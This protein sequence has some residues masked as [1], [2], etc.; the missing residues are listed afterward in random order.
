MRWISAQ[1]LQSWAGRR[2]CEDVLPE[3]LRRLVRA[4]VVAPGSAH[5]PSGE[6]IQVGGWD[7]VVQ[8]PAGNEFVPDGWSGWELSRRHDTTT[9][10]NDD[11]EK[12]TADPLQLDRATASFVFV[13]PRRWNAKDDWAAAK[14]A[15][16]EWANV[17]ALDADHLEQWLEQAPAVGAWLARKLGK[18]PNGV[19]SIDDYWTE[20][21]CG[22]NPP[23]TPES[24][25]AGRNDD[26]NRV[27]EWLRNGTG[28]LRLTAESPQEAFAFVAAALTLL[29]PEEQDQIRSRFLLADD[30]TVLR[31]IVT[32]G[33]QLTI[34]WLATDVTSIGAATQRGHR[35]IVPTTERE[36]PG[37]SITLTRPDHESLA[38]SLVTTGMSQDQTSTL[39]QEANDS[40]TILRRRLAIVPT[41]P[42]WG[43][44]ANARALI[45]AVLAISW[46]EQSPAEQTVVAG[47]AGTEYAAVAA[48]IARWARVSDAPVQQNGAVCSLRAPRDA[49]Y[50]LSP[51]IT[52][53]DLDQYRMAVTAVL[54]LR[55]PRLDLE[56]AERWLANIHGK[57]F[58]HSS[59]L[60]RGLAESL[61]FLSLTETVGGER[62]HDVARTIVHNL[63]TT[64]WERWYSLDHVLP[65]LAEAAPAIFLTQLEAALDHD[66]DGTAIFFESEGMMGGD[67]AT[68]LLW[69]LELLAWYPEHLTRVTLALARI[70]RTQE[71]AERILRAIFLSWLPQTSATSQQRGAALAVIMQREPGIGWRLLMNLWPKN[72]DVGAHHYEPKWREKPPV[73]PITVGERI[74]ADLIVVE[75]A[76]QHT[77]QDPARLADLIKHLGTAPP[78]AQTRL[79]EL[80]ATFTQEQRDETARRGVWNALREEVNKHRKFQDAPWALREEALAR[81]DPTIAALT[82]QDPVEQH[83]WLFKDA[84][85]TMPLHDPDPGML[86]TDEALAQRRRTAVQEIIAEHGVDGVCSLATRTEYPFLLGSSCAA[87][88][89]DET[90]M[91]AL[92]ASDDNHA[93]FCG[94]GYAYGRYQADGMN[95]VDQTLAAHEEWSKNAIAALLLA[96]PTDRT[97]WERVE[98]HE[99]TNEYWR[100]TTVFL[101]RDTP[102]ED[103]A[104]TLTHLLNAQQV[105]RALELASMLAAKTPTAVLTQV[106]DSILPALEAEPKRFSQLGYH[107]TQILNALDTRDDIEPGVIGRHEWIMLPL[108]RHDRTLR[109]HDELAKAPDL[110]AQMVNAIYR[111]DNEDD[112]EPATDEVIARAHHAEE[113]LSSWR[114][115]PGT[116]LD[117]TIDSGA[118]MDWVT[119]A[120]DACADRRDGCDRHIGQ[121]LAH[122]PAGTDGAW[123]C[124]AV[125]IVIDHVNTRALEHG[126]H[127]G[128]YNKRGTVT[129]DPFAGGVQERALVE[130]YRTWS[131]AL[132]PAWPRTAAILEELADQYDREAHREDVTAQLR[133]L[134]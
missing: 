98:Q 60:R 1:D 89:A 9:K 74:A 96:I 67:H 31:E 43:I 25:L 130:Q 53:Q 56:P 24:V 18:Y 62:G 120:R 78:H 119:R 3:L 84:Y 97:T 107:V 121:V 81:F 94:M 8:A 6:S 61:I 104:Y 68:G 64:D 42:E 5:F 71:R 29:P 20:Y 101:K 21:S 72:Y 34:G 117:G 86:L 44:P 131:R 40:I 80:L 110:F 126:F 19:L 39:L 79:Q 13:T 83:A 14:H 133:R 46:N 109:L 48:T 55:D 22:T 112:Q 91:L 69:A 57:E 82:P 108:L 49:W 129:A 4:T 51:F 33:Q 50:V 58:P 41:P 123:P 85:P 95:W 124:E 65:M 87:A 10:A 116:N 17:Y 75:L 23:L 70:A 32:T 90:A 37:Q 77:G 54:G 47:I 26:M 118:L 113:L 88:G 2:D 52:R 38:K 103:I 15:T 114:I 134:R 125:R 127:D 63:L 76:L 106:L 30:P 36:G 93:R 16:G 132:A 66:Q 45:P 115:V 28:A 12:R 100:A 122:A 102:A 73:P 105:P 99:V 92:L 35:V 11:Y 27:V 111:A 7:G 59:W 128:V